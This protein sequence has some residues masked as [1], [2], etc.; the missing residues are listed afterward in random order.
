MKLGNCN[1]LQNHFAQVYYWQD[2][3]QILKS[4]L[5]KNL[6]TPRLHC[7]GRVIF[8]TVVRD[9]SHFQ[10]SNLMGSRLGFVLRL[11][12]RLGFV[13]G[14]GFRLGLGLVSRFWLVLVMC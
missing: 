5:E 3:S 10:L 9:S 7:L 11:G 12:F 8:S 4:L 2:K 14:L 6:G 13:L 1:T